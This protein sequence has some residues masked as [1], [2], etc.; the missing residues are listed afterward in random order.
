[1][2]P[3]QLRSR[4]RGSSPFGLGLGSAVVTGVLS[5]S[6]Q[7]RSFHFSP[8]KSSGLGFSTSSSEG[9]GPHP[10]HMCTQLVSWPREVVRASMTTCASP[11]P[12]ALHPHVLLALF[13]PLHLQ[14]PLPAPRPLLQTSRGPAQSQSL[15]ASPEVYCSSRNW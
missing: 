6:L 2:R 1:M 9:L 10:P 3:V 7:P 4:Y 14:E 11:D 5:S 8:K 12:W 13:L 15:C